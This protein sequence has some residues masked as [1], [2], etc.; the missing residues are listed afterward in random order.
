[1]GAEVRLGV[2]ADQLAAPR[3]VFE[4]LFGQGGSVEQRRR[5]RRWDASILDSIA[6]DAS[7]LRKRLAPPIAPD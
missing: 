6:E 5:D 4:R 3:I 1:V 2:N 7:R